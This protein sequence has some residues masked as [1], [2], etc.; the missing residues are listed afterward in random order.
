MIDGNT[1]AQ[2]QRKK[3]TTGVIGEQITEWQNV[4]TISGYLDLA[5]GDSKYTEFRAT[6]RL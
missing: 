4:D 2:I 5:T 3:V 6:Y 1:I